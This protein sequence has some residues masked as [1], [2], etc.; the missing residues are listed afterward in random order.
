[1]GHHAIDHVVQILHTGILS[2]VTLG[3]LLHQKMHFANVSAAVVGHF[4]VSSHNQGSQ[5]LW[6]CLRRHDRHFRTEGSHSRDVTREV[7]D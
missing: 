7:I 3:L 5:A 1:M 6:S 4:A 2:K